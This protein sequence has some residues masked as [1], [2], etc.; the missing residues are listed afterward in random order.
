RRQPRPR[1]RPRRPEL[2]AEHNG[3]R[4]FGELL[5]QGGGAG[6]ESAAARTHGVESAP[7]TDDRARFHRE[8]SE[9]CGER[10]RLTALLAL[11]LAPRLGRNDKDEE[12]WFAGVVYC[13]VRRGAVRLREQEAGGP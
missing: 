11:P 4:C 9:L 1:L 6:V 10:A 2:R 12:A 8:L 3:G 7:W 5:S 13:L